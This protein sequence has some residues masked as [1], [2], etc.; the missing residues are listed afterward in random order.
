MKNLKICFKMNTDISY[1][2]DFNSKIFFYIRYSSTVV[3][4]LLP[5]RYYTCT[6]YPYPILLSAK[7]LVFV[8]VACFMTFLSH[9]VHSDCAKPFRLRRMTTNDVEVK[10]LIRFGS[11]LIFKGVP[12]QKGPTDSLFDNFHGHL[13]YYVD[14]SVFTLVVFMESWW[15]T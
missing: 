11:H 12:S 14:S 9:L 15:P 4:L 3:I 1:S 2:S 13:W 7:E 5:Y 8:N 6:P 10:W